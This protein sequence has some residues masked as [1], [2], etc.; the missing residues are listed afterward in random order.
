MKTAFINKIKNSRKNLYPV[1]P[2]AHYKDAEEG[3]CGVTGFACTIPVRGKHIFEPSRLMHNR[4]NGK[5]GG[6]AA[7]GL[8]AEDLGVTEEVLNECYLIQIALLD[9]TARKEIEEKFIKPYMEI[10][11]EGKIPAVDDY[12]EVEE[13]EIRPPDVWRYFVRV[14]QDVLSKFAV[15]NKLEDMDSRRVEDEFIWQNTIRLNQ[16]FYDTQGDKKAFVLSHGRNMMILKIVGYAEKVAQYYKLENVRAHAWIA[17][18]RYPTKGRVWHPAGAHPFMGLDEAL[19][20]NGDF[21]NY[22]S[23]AEYLRQK[24]IYPHFQTDTEVA[25]LMYDLLNRVYGY[26][27]EYIIEALAPT[28]EMD[29]DQ[30]PEE[31]QKIYHLLQSIHIH[32]SPDGPWFFIIARNDFYHKQFQLSGITDT[33]MLRPQV[34]AFHDGEVQVGLICSEKQAIDATLASLAEEDSRICPVADKYWN[35]R[36]GSHTDGG[37][38]IFNIS[39]DPENPGH[40]RMVCTDKFGKKVEVSKNQQACDMSLIINVPDL[41]DALAKTISE[42]LDSADANGL[43]T[44]IKEQIQSGDFNKLRWCCEKI[45]EK[46]V[47]DDGK[48][49]TAIDALTFLNDLRYSTGALKRSSVL[50]IIRRTLKKI[51]GTVVSIGS[52]DESTFRLITWN[53][54]NDLIAPVGKQ[55][56]LVLNGAGF[57]P[58]GDDCDARLVC[59]A[60]SA[61]WKKFIC[62]GYRGQRFL[63]CGLGPKTNDVQID[64]YGSSGDYLASGID[65][66]TI[67]VHGNAQDQLGQILK[68]GKLIIYGDA[69]QTFMYGAKGGEVYVMGNVAGRPFVNATGRPRAVI[70]GT[71]LDYLAESFMAGDPMNGGGFVILNGM[72]F[73]NEGGPQ[74]QAT[75]YSGSNIFSL[76]SGG[77]IYVRDP[78]NMLVEEQ[79]NGGAFDRLNKEDWRLILP[80]L[81]ENERLFNISIEKDLLVVDG[82]SKNPEE[83]YKKIVPKR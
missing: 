32:G 11:S 19:V 68:L 31:K 35:A 54:R 15:K 3:G 51:F 5:G 77:A 30:L 8:V 61:G 64:V 65:G 46:S 43:Y 74:P 80:Y 38:F 39:D 48:K 50:Y 78:H 57:P 55:S 71:A 82:N 52:D 59:D 62:Y 1:P 23:V 56:T 12:R 4:G 67:R 49:Q 41:S 53:T 13:L 6:I 33:A 10:S 69:G 42:Y 60:Y 29:F 58:E 24:N 83:V 37:A 20:H 47:E 28:T 7:V 17:H 16:A 26:P 18:Q 21:A 9:P 72:E 81:K 45:S 34:F 25:V 73:D 36:G 76:A 2:S 75:P 40:K 66:M 44:F 27:L 70:N 14:K 79:L 63:G 22:Y